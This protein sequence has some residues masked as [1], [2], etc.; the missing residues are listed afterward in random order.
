MGSVISS[1]PAEKQVQAMHVC[2]WFLN[3]YAWAS[4]EGPNN[5]PNCRPVPAQ[6]DHLGADIEK[7]S[8]VCHNDKQGW[9][10]V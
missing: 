7:S 10:R 3:S 9:I 8:P 5:R 2:L 4:I 6:A 1:I